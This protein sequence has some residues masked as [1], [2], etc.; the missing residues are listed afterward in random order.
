MPISEDFRLSRSDLGWLGSGL[1][2]PECIL[3]TA[4]GDI[5]TSDLR[6]GISHI[7]PDGSIATYHGSA[8]TGGPLAANG[9][10]MMAD[11][12]FLIAPLFGGP[13]QR[14]YRDGRVEVFLAEVDGHT[15]HTPNFV[16]RDHEDRVWI[17]TRSHGPAQHGKPFARD[18]R[19]GMVIL[20]D[21]R[22]ARIV[23]DGLAFPNEVRIDPVRGYAYTNETLA[24]GFYRHRL[25]P[26]LGFGAP[27]LLN[28][29]DDTNILDGFELDAEGG[30]WQTTVVSN[31][32]W[33]IAPDG[34]VR[35]L[36]EDADADQLRRLS[37]FQRSTGIPRDLMY[38]P[39]GDRL[40]G[41]ASIAFGGPD[42]RT[43]C[44]G[45]LMGT[46]VATFRAPVAGIPPAHWTHGG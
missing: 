12:S 36:L 8:V 11:G 3:T 9:Y 32:I 42:L 4:R 5:Y 17:C 16:L 18:L 21:A 30:I 35:L 20:V 19:E 43:A 25:R 27:E 31:R 40:P 1:S 46:A 33:Y 26:D 13:V 2:R 41:L 44:L 14:L 29:F 10:A 15:I 39:P 6:G 45:S 24:G 7:R 28:Q 38:E 23:A 22:G 37:Q 34:T